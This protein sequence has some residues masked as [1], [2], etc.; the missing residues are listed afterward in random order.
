MFNRL[1]IGLFGGT[2]EGTKKQR[3]ARESERD[4]HVFDKQLLVGGVGKAVHRDFEF[5][6]SV[7]CKFFGPQ[8]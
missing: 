1:I 4:G 2:N 3:G 7:P 8:K 5:D 6:A